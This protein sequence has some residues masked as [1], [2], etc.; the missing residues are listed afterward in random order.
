[1]TAGLIPFPL[2]GQR[3]WCSV[4][5]LGERFH[6]ESLRALFAEV[7]RGRR[8][9]VDG[10]A[11]LMPEPNS[12]RDAVRVVCDGL[13][14]GYLPAALAVAYR[15]VVARLEAAGHVA[16]V[17]FRAWG[18]EYEPWGAERDGGGP[19]ARFSG[20]VYLDLAEPHLVLPL[21]DRPPGAVRELP[22]GT[23]IQVWGEEH[24]LA[25]LR[26]YT[27]TEGEAWVYAT[28][29]PV[30]EELARS[31]RSLVEV[32]VDGEP[33]GRLTPR[34]S[35]AVLPA[36]EHVE[37]RGATAV[38]RALVKGTAIRAEVLLHVQRAHEI[39]PDWLEGRTDG[40]RSR[41]APPSD[42]ADDHADDPADDQDPVAT[43]PGGSEP[44]AAKPSTPP[45]LQP[46]RPEAR[47]PGVPTRPMRLVFNLPP[48]WPPP[49]DGWEPEPGWRPP[50]DWP[51]A[52]EGWEYWV[53]R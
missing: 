34:M 3:G 46:A 12:A 2:W 47:H 4:E 49:P 16:T 8:D 31:T 24:Y 36:V 35:G 42:P 53:G 9:E 51:A 32:R 33:V 15:P 11:Y 19:G 17:A 5:V 22:V 50:G 30:L 38:A 7:P 40:P 48:G 18:E 21:N 25:H 6:E 43:G 39:A 23:A 52:P 13:H 28:L 44:P 29:H 37:R 14:V 10:T 27:R 20:G 41:V 45:A 1:M 26:A